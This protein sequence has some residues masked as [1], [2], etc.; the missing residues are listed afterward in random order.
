MDDKHKEAL[1]RR[2][3]GNN[4][5]SRANRLKNKLFK[6][7]LQEVISANDYEKALKVIEAL[8]QKAEE[9][10]L[11]AIDIVLERID[12]KVP[13]ENKIDGRLDGNLNHSINRPMRIITGIPDEDGRTYTDLIPDGKGGSY[14]LKKEDYDRLEVTPE[15]AK[16]MDE[17]GWEGTTVEFVEPP[18]R[19]ADG[20]IVQDDS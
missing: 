17:E 11:R 1:S 5:S 6:E 4:H 13:N 2:N 15:Q 19:D 8:I 20:N 10:D 12:G 14:P 18:Q 9:G 7:M 16:K 3:R